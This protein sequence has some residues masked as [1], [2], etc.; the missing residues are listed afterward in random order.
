MAGAGVLVD[1]GGTVD[2]TIADAGGV[3]EASMTTGSGAIEHAVSAT[4]STP[5]ST[6]RALFTETTLVTANRP[7]AAAGPADEQQLSLKFVKTGCQATDRPLVTDAQTRATTDG[8]Q[9]RRAFATAILSILTVIAASIGFGGPERAQA[10]ADSDWLTIVNTYRAMSGLAPVT[11]NATWSSEAQAHSCYMLQNGISHDEVP[12]LPGYTPGGDTAGNSGNVA[13]SSV[14]S[15]TPRNHIDLWMTGPFHAIGIL[16]HN[17]TSSGFGLCAAANTPTP[18]HSGG[19]LDV[20]RGIDNSL[21]RPTTPIVFPGD[22]ATVPLH[23]FIT[24][25]PNPMTLCGWTGNAGLPLIAMMPND[26]TSANATITGPNGPVPTCA[27]HAGNTSGD[28]TARAILDGDNAVVVMP[29]ETLADGTYT[30]TV[31]TN[32]GNV[33][34][35]FTVKR[36]APLEVVP[37]QTP[38][39]SPTTLAAR[40][41]PVTPFRLVDTRKNLG[42]ASLR[43]GKVTRLHVGA[44]DVVAISANFTVVSPSG[45]GYITAYNCTVERP[46]VSTLGFQPGQTIANQAIVPLKQGDLCVFSLVDADLIIDVN[47]YYRAANDGSGFVPVKPIRLLDSRD[48]G[49]AKLK[50]GVEVRLKVAG[51]DGGAPAGTTGVALNVTVIEPQYYG[52]LQV[53]P[54]GVTSSVDVSNVNYVPDEYRP[55]SVVS[56]VGEGGKVCMRSLRDTDVAI[57][58]TGYFSAD[59][60][61]DFMALDPVRLFDSRS[62]SAGLN[63]ATSGQRLRAGQVVRVQIAGERGIPA[64]AKAVSV[65]LTATDTLDNT[66]L[67]AYPCGTIPTTSNVNL[68]TSQFVNA[69][70]AMVKL[71]AGGELCVYS[72]KSVHLIVDI[73]GIFQ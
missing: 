20:I 19:T 36:N 9:R 34:W 70:G 55:N 27:L 2:A 60:G 3:L 68:V 49:V 14:M 59:K 40:F 23:S 67:T 4:P 44:S 61:L 53:Y 7:R 63:E 57:D 8:P 18:W 38:D 24:E 15:A 21:A 45:Y 66:Y 12:G 52:H 64:D 50:A 47:G 1:G 16:R 72:K 56:P 65:N 10:V 26:V 71:S 46:T 73:N 62:P 35:S 5:P 37:P 31:N 13:V 6:V 11:A 54:C 30:V 28:A 42:T 51:V 33:T 48:K 41:E 43:A 32:S 17:L 29:R 22:G 58:L 39:T 69:N 25:F